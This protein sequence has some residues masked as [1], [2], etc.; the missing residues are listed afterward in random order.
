MTPKN[1]AS[2]TV[3]GM[4][5]TIAGLAADPKN[6]KE[7][8]A[9]ELG[10]ADLIK[11]LAP[12]NA[13]QL[14]VHNVAQINSKDMRVGHWQALLSAVQEAVSKPHTQ[15]VVITHGTDTLEETAYLLQAMGP[16]PK[17]WC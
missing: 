14:D 2:I 7:Y 13:F 10:I 12:S 4:G 17:P 16:W 1:I 5:G 6:S 11:N 9:G 8:I 3:L 15:A